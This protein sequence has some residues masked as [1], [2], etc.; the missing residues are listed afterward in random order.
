M[1]VATVLL[2]GK[3]KYFIKLGYSFIVKTYNLPKKKNLIKNNEIQY[4]FYDIVYKG[5]VKNLTKFLRQSSS[6]SEECY[7]SQTLTQLFK[8][9]LTYSVLST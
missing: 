9:M 4:F 5:R 3:G 1:L 2:L 6:K 7:L 8:I